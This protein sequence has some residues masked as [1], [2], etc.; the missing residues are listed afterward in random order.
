MLTFSELGKLVFREDT[1]LWRQ[2]SQN[3]TILFILIPN[4]NLY[5]VAALIAT[6]YS[7]CLWWSYEQEKI[8]ILENLIV[9][10]NLNLDLQPLQRPLLLPPYILVEL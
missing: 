8:S 4:L 9:M 1:T 10:P 5:T 7:C 6:R 3:A 2:C